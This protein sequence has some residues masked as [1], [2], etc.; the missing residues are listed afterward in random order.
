MILDLQKFISHERP[1]WEELDEM[2][3][4]VEND[5]YR[6]LSFQEINRFHYLYERASAG[7]VKINTF[8]VEA[9]IR[10]Y[11]ESMVGRSYTIIYGHRENIIRFSPVKWFWRTFPQ[12]FR[13]HFHLFVLSLCMM[14][15][16]GLFGATALVIDPH[17]KAVLLPFE[18][19]QAD[20]RDRVAE[21]EGHKSEEL[22][23]QGK[24][25]FSA[26]LIT[27]NTR[28][29]IFVLALGM[30]WGI[31]T[32]LLLF[33]N[34]VILGAVMADY[35]QA[36]QQVFLTGW[37][38]PHGAIEIPSILIAG[39]AG[40]VL[41]AALM[42]GKSGN[43]MRQRL[44]NIGPDLVTLIGGVAVLLIWAGLVEAFFSQYHE[45]VIPYSVKIIFGFSELVMLI[46]YLTFAGKTIPFGIKKV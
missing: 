32:A 31:G 37:L 16:G 30:T 45:P 39:Q 7:L 41:A 43:P 4:A 23:K 15:V 33:S 17:A 40:L 28:V 11:L 35:I 2:L 18:H 19:L 21:E 5:P 22:K 12:T 34:G 1:F 42:G 29:S 24:A 27:N 36:G 25:S 20:P 13:R 44:R 6:N 8:T 10:R 46:L 38:L 26:F 14:V 3:T 9:D